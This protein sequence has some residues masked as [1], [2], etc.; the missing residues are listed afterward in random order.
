MMNQAPGDDA[1][2]GDVIECTHT[3]RSL[4]R[5]GIFTMRR[6]AQLSRAELMAIRG[7]GKVIA[8]ETE[9]AVTKWRRA[10][11]NDS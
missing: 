4:E 9:R 11:D 7:I 8:D 5:A 3:V 10:Y 6:L 1:R 2:I